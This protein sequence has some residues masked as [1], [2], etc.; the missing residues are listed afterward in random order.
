MS[1]EDLVAFLKKNVIAV[2]CVAASIAIGVTIY[3]RSDL[4]P[5]AEK[6]FLDN[7]QK[8]A[9]IAANIED[10]EHLPDQ[11]AALVAANQAIAGR[12]VNVGQLAENDQYF[13][14]IETKT[15]IKLTDLRPT[16]WAPPPKGA[17]KTI[18]TRVG[19]ALTAE[20]TYPQLID[21]LR[22]LEN[23]EHYC[24]ILSCNI[25]PNSEA[26]GSTLQMSLALELLAVQ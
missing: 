24:R 18:Y 20:G 5:Q 17:P 4:L 6:V 12:L 21:L 15:G 9:L 7:A 19:Y 3:L 1:N 22:K 11:H 8:A 2:A 25:H 16:P 10:Y 14:R 23:G 26:R 13:Y